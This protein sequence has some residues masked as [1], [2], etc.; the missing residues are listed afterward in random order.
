MSESPRTDIGK[1]ASTIT[2]IANTKRGCFFISLSFKSINIQA[3][4]L[5]VLKRIPGLYL[6]RF[7]E[8]CDLI[9]KQT[10]LSFKAPNHLPL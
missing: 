3:M 4:V 1:T 9:G 2:T 8:R 5:R 10:L 6:G 7:F